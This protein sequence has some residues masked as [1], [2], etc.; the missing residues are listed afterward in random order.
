MASG[1]WGLPCSVT[2]KGLEEVVELPYEDT[3][4]GVWF[5]MR[6]SLPLIRSS[7]M[8]SIFVQTL[9]NNSPIRLS[10][11]HFSGRGHWAPS[12]GS[13]TWK[14]NKNSLQSKSKSVKGYLKKKIEFLSSESTFVGQRGTLN[15]TACRSS[16]QLK[17]W[18]RTRWPEILQFCIEA[19]L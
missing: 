17:M 1:R 12:N 2:E 11:N 16:A 3:S 6:I 14:R 18:M 9:D 7:E 5:K 19:L 15:F 8:E 13:E 10:Q 4:D